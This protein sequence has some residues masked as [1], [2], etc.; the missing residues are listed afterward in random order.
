MKK[1]NV[2]NLIRY[3]CEKNDKAFKDEAYLIARDFNISGDNQLGEYIICLLA[4][5]NI[6]EPQ[7][8]NL[9]LTFF[10]KIEPSSTEFI[11]PLSIKKD[12]MGV[13][14][15]VAKNV[16]INKFLFEGEPG[17]GKTESVKHLARILNRD[18]YS[19]QFDVVIDSK[20]G[21]T[22]KNITSLFNEI[23][24]LPHPEKAIILFDEIDAIALDRLNNNDLREMGRAT[25]SILRE[26]DNLSDKIVF[27]ATTNL[28]K[29]F[30]K[31][32]IR[33]F[34]KVINFN[35]YDKDDLIEVGT[36]IL[37]DYLKKV[38][39]ENNNV[40]LFKKILNNASYLPYPGNLKNIIKTSVAFS[41]ANNETD[42][43]KQLYLTIN[44]ENEL[45]IRDLQTKG[46]TVREIETL[47]GISKSKVSRELNDDE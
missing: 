27:I 20:L 29:S 38:N 6:F 13:V 43:L 12:L 33:R 42:Y 28:Y 25:S 47:T 9:N 14:N 11:I 26:L 19:V 34:D 17:T 8:E 21:Q 30:D 2:I 1:K 31:A 39:I 24:N 32:L 46:F 7:G 37:K 36:S 41:D 10:K 4:G 15:A 35:N 5:A 22:S 23:H 18:L 44:G 3:H 16:G 45:D 40:K